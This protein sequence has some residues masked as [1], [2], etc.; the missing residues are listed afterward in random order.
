MR[1]RGSLAKSFLIA[2]TFALIPVSAISAQKI[3][4]GS[5]CKVLNQKIA[6]QNKTYTCIKSG[7]KLVWNKGVV[8][9]KPTPAPTVT[10]TATPTP[11][12]TVT[13]TATPTPAPTVTV[14]A[15]PVPRV[16]VT[17]TPAPT[18]IKPLIP[19]SIKA[20]IKFSGGPTTTTSWG[21][22]LSYLY[23]VVPADAALNNQLTPSYS[24]AKVNWSQTNMKVFDGSNRLLGI[25]SSFPQYQQFND[26]SCS[27]SFIL[28]DLV[29]S[30]GPLTFRT[31]SA[32]N[33][34]VAYSDWLDGEVY[35]NGDST[36]IRF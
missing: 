29:L 4:P 33:W 15:T 13:V 8:V 18:V 23:C 22:G 21:T 3:T 17:A 32:P 27:I 20:T 10:V 30:Q 19:T 24:V 14:T 2:L 34:T 25:A 26:G 9:R 7:K 36:V 16:T 6:Y 28:S 1:I 31:G 11:A 35:L 5:T 12:P